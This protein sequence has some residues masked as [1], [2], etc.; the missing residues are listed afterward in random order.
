LGLGVID[1]D[2]D[3]T[4]SAGEIGAAPAALLRLDKDSDSRI[5]AEDVRA[6]MQQFRGRGGPEGGPGGRGQGGGPRGPEGSLT[7]NIV[8]DALKTFMAFDANGDGKLSKAELPERMQGLFSRGDENKDGFLASDEIRKIATA[9]AAPAQ[10]AGPGGPGGPEGRRGGFGGDVNPIRMDPVF[11]IVDA[12]G[13]GVITVEEVGGSPK[14]LRKLDTNGDGKV[15][16]DE[17]A[18]IAKQAREAQERRP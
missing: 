4:L 15:T 17:V 9:Q 1:A 6:M 7:V 3:G 18:A 13:D 5:T 10:P 2:G 16:P 12:D 11:A 8:D 14:A